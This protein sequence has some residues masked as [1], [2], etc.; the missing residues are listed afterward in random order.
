M[1]IKGYMLLA[2]LAIGLPAL[3]YAVHVWNKPYFELEKNRN[4]IIFRSVP[5]YIVIFLGETALFKIWYEYQ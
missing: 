2:V 3:Y 5:E 4:R 1:D